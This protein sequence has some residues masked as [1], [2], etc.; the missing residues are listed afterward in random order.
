MRAVPGGPAAAARLAAEAEAVQFFAAEMGR[1]AVAGPIPTATTGA[2]TLPLERGG[3]TLAASEW[4]PGEPLNPFAYAWLRDAPL[5]R[6]FGDWLARSHAAGR[7][8]VR[9]KPDLAARLPTFEA[10]HDGLMAGWSADLSPE[11]AAAMAPPSSGGTALIIHSDANVSNCHATRKEGDGGSSPPSPP[12]SLCFFDWD[13]VHWGCPEWDA[14]SAAIIVFMFAEAGQIFPVPGAPVPEADPEA[15]VGHLLAGYADAAAAV[16]GP[17][18]DRARFDRMVA[19]RKRFVGAF[20]ERSAG[21]DP[22]PGMA[23]Y[24]EYLRGWLD[25]QG[26]RRVGKEEEAERAV[27]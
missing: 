18:L 16:G 5:I 6:S 4:A 17:P 7:K 10:L 23:A 22:P 15:F 2:L 24:L 3:V 25:G 8:L 14:A 9:E 12:S 27:A 19:L 13:Q 26:Q 11:D 20:A 21:E 1:G